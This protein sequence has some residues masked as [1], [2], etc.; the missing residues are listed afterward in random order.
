MV[1][2]NPQ[3]P[4]VIDLQTMKARLS[5]ADKKQLEKTVSN[6]EAVYM[7]QMLSQM[8]T[9]IDPNSEFGGGVGEEMFRGL[10]TEQYAQKITK[11]GNG[12]LSGVLEREM[13]RMQAV[14][15]NPRALIRE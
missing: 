9:D 15:S 7:G 5:D 4:Q 10:L 2:F 13:L 6:F 1:A 11:D 14:A 3:A 8:Y 12:P